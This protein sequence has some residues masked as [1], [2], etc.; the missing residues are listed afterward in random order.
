[1]PGSDPGGKVTL[2]AEFKKTLSTVADFYTNLQG[3]ARGN[4]NYIVTQVRVKLPN[5]QIVT[6]TAILVSGGR[7][8]PRLTAALNAE[9][10]GSVPVVAAKPGTGQSGKGHSEGVN[11]PINRPNLENKLGGTVEGM[12]AAVSAIPVCS[13]TCANDLSQLAG[14]TVFKD[15]RGF[16]GDYDLVDVKGTTAVPPIK[17]ISQGIDRIANGGVKALGFAGDIAMMVDVG[18]HWDDAN[19]RAEQICALIGACLTQQMIDNLYFKYG[20]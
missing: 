10:L 14:R 15:S 13:Q 16:V 1:V 7:I 9:G 18:V 3:W 11:D 19:W 4:A 6:K 2:T 17:V 5:G 20:T 12:D 8:D